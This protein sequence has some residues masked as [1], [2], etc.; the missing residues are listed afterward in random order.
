MR[1]LLI[2]VLTVAVSGSLAIS[3]A[4]AA[5]APPPPS[6][7][8]GK[9]NANPCRDEVSAALQ[10]LRK[11]SW[12]RME[13]NMLTENGPTE[14]AV[15]YILPDKMHQVTT[16]VTTKQTV[17]LILIGKQ[18]WQK[19]GKGW[20]AVPEELTQ[21]YVAQMQENVV[22]QQADVGNYSCK[23]RM[24]VEGREVMAYKLE[25]D[26]AKGAEGPKNE[27]FRMFY[28]D[29]TTGLPVGNELVTPGR[30]GKPFFRT[31]YSFPI[32]LKVEQPK[33]VMATP[34]AVAQPDAAKADTSKS[35][36]PEPDAAKP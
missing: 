13:S 21:Q 12:F 29:A 26:P 7:G 19:E 16:V 36:A 34:A 30:E 6:A 5:D 28:V 9:E 18:A 23:G 17:E 11:S 33:D 24:K 22:D 3:M 10:K 32:D 1:R 8:K 2:S 35:G 4:W 25:D 20:E 27:A 15:D 14:M 31:S